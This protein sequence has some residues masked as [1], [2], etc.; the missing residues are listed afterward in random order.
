MA[1]FIQ[2]EFAQQIG[3]ISLDLFVVEIAPREILSGVLTVQ[4]S[5]GFFAGLTS[6]HLR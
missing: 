2:P 3:D 6:L 4:M 1:V 5:L